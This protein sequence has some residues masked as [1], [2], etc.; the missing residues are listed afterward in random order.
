V[1]TITQLVRNLFITSVPQESL[2]FGDENR[3][4]AQPGEAS[5]TYPVSV[6]PDRKSLSSFANAV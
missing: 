4:G 3:P 1:Q 2:L 6:L 5:A